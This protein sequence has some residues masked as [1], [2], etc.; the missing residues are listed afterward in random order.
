MDPALLPDEVRAAVERVGTA[1][2]VVGLATSGPIPALAAVAAAVRAGLDTHFSGHAAAVVH[3]DQ[4]PSEATA[5]VAAAFRSE[6]RRVGKE[7]RL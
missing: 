7:C 2:L 1:D 4:A 3:V 5:A 6:E